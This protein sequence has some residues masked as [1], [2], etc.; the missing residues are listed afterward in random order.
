VKLQE[1]EAAAEIIEQKPLFFLNCFM[2]IYGKE[3]ERERERER[4]NVTTEKRST[5]ST[6]C[7]KA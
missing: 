2:G 3:R 4:E 1:I 5:L 7:S 6:D